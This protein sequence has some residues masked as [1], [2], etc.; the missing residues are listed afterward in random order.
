MRARSTKLF[1]VFLY[2]TAV[3]ESLFES[4]PRHEN[5]TKRPMGAYS[6]MRQRRQLQD[7]SVGGLSK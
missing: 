2:G 1:Q 5:E 3:T 6:V 7:F 4:V